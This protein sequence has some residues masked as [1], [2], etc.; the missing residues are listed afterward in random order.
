MKKHNP[1]KIDYGEL[2]HEIMTWS[3]AYGR[4]SRKNGKQ[5]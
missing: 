4:K 3:P 1:E 5:N 2:V